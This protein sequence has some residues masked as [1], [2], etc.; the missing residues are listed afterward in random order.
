MS[1]SIDI[2]LEGTHSRESLLFHW[3]AKFS[4]GTN[5]E[6]FNFETG[7]EIRFQEVKDNFDKLEYFILYNKEKVFTVDLLNG[8]IYFN[9]ELKEKQEQLEKKE[10]IRL[11]FFR[12]HKVEIGTVD[13]KEKKH[14]IIYHLGYQY[15]DKNGYNNKIIL[16]IDSEGNWV[17]GE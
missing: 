16:Q 8:F 2:N 6:Q 5:L 11:I 14:E 17:L 4:D 15:L 10:N 1:N 9:K 13:L 12:R 3:Y 7:K